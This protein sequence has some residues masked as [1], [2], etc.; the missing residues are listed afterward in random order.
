[1]TAEFVKAGLDDPAAVEAEWRKNGRLYLIREGI[2]RSKAMKDVMDTA[3][4]TEVDY[5]AQ[6]QEEKKASKKSSTKKK[7]AKKDE[8]AEATEESAE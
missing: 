4:V 2:V 1:M 8:A 6:A 5:A 3:K 7:A